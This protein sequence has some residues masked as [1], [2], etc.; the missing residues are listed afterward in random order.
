MFFLLPLPDKISAGV[1]GVLSGGSSV[2]RP[3]SEEPQGIT[4]GCSVNW[5]PSD[6]RGI[7]AN[8]TPLYGIH[9]PEIGSSLDVHL[10][11]LFFYALHP[12]VQH[13][14]Q[15]L[16][17]WILFPL[18]KKS[19]MDIFLP[20]VPNQP[21]TTGR[22]LLPPIVYWTRCFWLKAVIW[23]LLKSCDFLTFV[24]FSVS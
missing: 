7:F 13:A 12:G 14:A 20:I 17:E 5:Q 1:D 3:G 15:L 22:A 23:T 9:S 21:T 24:M 4:E 19:H 10:F 18:L 11:D 16:E 8:P 2:R 6:R